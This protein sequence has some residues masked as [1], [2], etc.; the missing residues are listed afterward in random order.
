PCGQ[1]RSDRVPRP[2]ASVMRA[3]AFTFGRLRPVFDMPQVVLVRP[4]THR[5][6]GSRAAVTAGLH[7]AEDVLVSCQV[8]FGVIG[9][10]SL[11]ELPA[12]VKAL[13]YPVPYCPPD[14]VVAALRAFV[15]RDGALYFSGDISYD[16]QRKLT[17]AQRLVELAGVER[18]GVAD[19]KVAPCASATLVEAR[20][21]TLLPGLAPA[22]TAV[23]LNKLGPGQVFFCAAPVESMGTPPEW[24]RP[25]MLEFLRRAGVSRNPV[26]PDLPTLQCFR[27]PLQGG[28]AAW[29]LLNDSDAPVTATLSLPGKAGSVQMALAARSPGLVVVDGQGRLTAVEAQGAVTRNDKAV[30]TILGHAII[31]SLDGKDLSDCMQALLLPFPGHGTVPPTAQAAATLQWAGLAG[32]RIELGELQGTKWMCLEPLQAGRDGSLSYDVEQS[33]QMI[34][35][36][37][38]QQLNA[39][40]ASVERFATSP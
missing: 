38:P 7:R 4:D 11:G 19:A 3:L 27:A 28:G 5:L 1:V 30:V 9:E 32:K 36:A 17:R 15:E 18:K 13:V 20:G 37:T 12:R 2:S 39:A 35:A 34:L 10:A 26:A 6:G 8:D 24:A 25:L 23:A 31:Q 33:L 21:V 22:G 14:E 29:V 40:R 16:P